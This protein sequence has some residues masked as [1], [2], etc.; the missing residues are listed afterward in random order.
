MQI[1]YLA[2]ELQELVHLRQREQGND[3]LFD[4]ELELGPDDGNFQWD[5]TPEDYHFWQMVNDEDSDVLDSIHYP[6]PI[7]NTFPIY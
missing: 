1:K 4:G 3:G 7:N 5:Q 2:P 6:K